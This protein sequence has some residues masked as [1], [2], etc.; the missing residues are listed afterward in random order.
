MPK[1]VIGTTLST[2][3]HGSTDY[4]IF[5][6]AGWCYL[7]QQVEAHAWTSDGLDPS[8]ASCYGVSYITGTY[9]T[10]GG[11]CP[12]TVAAPKPG[13]IKTVVLDTTKTSTDLPYIDLTTACGLLSAGS[14]GYN[15]INFSSLASDVQSVTLIGLTTAYWGLLAIAGST[16]F[17]QNAAGIRSSTT[18]SS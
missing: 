13:C 7:R 11:A 12:L 5:A 17:W 16:L 2:S 10:D 3:F 1:N 15:F 8:T 6:P 18:P 9:G 4:P 14:S